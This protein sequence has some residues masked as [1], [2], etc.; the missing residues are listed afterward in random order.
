MDICAHELVHLTTYAAL[1]V[2]FR[3]TAPQWVDG[4]EDSLSRIHHAELAAKDSGRE[5]LWKMNIAAFEALRSQSSAPVGGMPEGPRILAFCR[6]DPSLFYRQQYT[7]GRRRVRFGTELLD[8]LIPADLSRVPHVLD[9][10][11]YTSLGIDFDNTLPL[12]ASEGQFNHDSLTHEQFWYIAGM[13]GGSRLLW[14]LHLTRFEVAQRDQYSR[15]HWLDVRVPHHSVKMLE[16]LSQKEDF[17]AFVV[18]W[19]LAFYGRWYNFPT[20]KATR[21]LV[22]GVLEAFGLPWVTQDETSKKPTTGT[23]KTT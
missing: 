18:Y 14:Q 21:S 8:P 12:M 2:D 23:G 16:G 7:P 5:T 9:L 1:G 20:E 4:R 19:Y 3:R 11:L 15:P 13:K 22:R 10:S 17:G 6:E